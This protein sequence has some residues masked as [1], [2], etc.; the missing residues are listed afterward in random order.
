[1]RKDKRMPKLTIKE[2][3]KIAGVSPAAVSIVLN[4]K[5]GVSDETRSKISDL[6]AK[7]QY[8]PNPNSRRLLFNKTNNITVLIKRDTSPLENIFYSELN[9]V[10]V[11]ECSRYN[12]NL[13]FTSVY[14]ENGE[15][16]FPQVIKSYD[17]D[18]V[19]FYGDT[20]S[21]IISGLKNFELPYIVIDTHLSVSS[22]LCVYA[23]YMEAAYTAASYLI[24]LGHRRIAHIGNQ[25]LTNY[26][27]QTF[28]GFKK[29][30]EENR[31]ELPIHWI[32]LD[33][34]DEHTASDSMRRILSHNELPTAIFC[35]SD[36]LAIGA[37]RCIKDHG[38]R[39]PED[40]SVI[41]IDDI[42]LSRY[43]EPPLTT[44]KIDREEMAKYAVQL[45]IEKI[46][47]KES[48]PESYMS[49]SNQIIVRSSTRAY[50]ESS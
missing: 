33:A 9:R 10:V 39:V 43:I 1:M 5:K 19:I 31:F 34:A 45:L 14:Y 23:D 4:N 46:N 2:I 48:S 22:S 37:I 47:D 15:V 49:T 26:S 28:N 3:A 44:V 41:G 13:I 35:A 21:E 7:L 40:I 24:E 42:I 27:V 30:M 50:S 17:V 12:Y 36:I 8:A 32:Q 18:G 25:L 6:V 29:A 20:D 16:V 38:L 11:D